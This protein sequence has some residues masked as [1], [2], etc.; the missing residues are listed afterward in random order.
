MV[1]NVNFLLFF[2]LTKSS[3]TQTMRK[4]VWD[5]HDCDNDLKN[6]FKIL[7]LFFWCNSIQLTIFEI[8]NKQLVWRK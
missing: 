8:V 7:K 5:G 6:Q 3:K 4:K 1:T 2:S